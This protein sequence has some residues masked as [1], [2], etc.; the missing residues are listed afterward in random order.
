MAKKPKQKHEGKPP[1]DDCVE[2]ENI[3]HLVDARMRI[4][5]EEGARGKGKARRA[6]TQKSGSAAEES[7]S[8]ELLKALKPGVGARTMG[9]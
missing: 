8:L 2:F 6:K 1:I 7:K 9:G 3:T 4:K 5:E